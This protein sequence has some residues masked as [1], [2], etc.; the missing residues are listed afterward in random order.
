MS[1]ISRDKLFFRRNAL[2]KEY[3][4]HPGLLFLNLYRS[5]NNSFYIVQK[6]YQDFISALKKYESDISL[7][8]MGNEVNRHLAIMETL[9]TL[10]NYL[11]SVLSLI[12]HSRTFIKNECP[13]LTESI[14]SQIDTLSQKGCVKFTREFRNFIQHKN[15]PSPSMKITYIRE[16]NS[17]EQKI[18]FNKKD[19]LEWD[20]WSKKSRKYI[21]SFGEELT[22]NKLFEDYQKLNTK[23]YKLIC[24]KAVYSHKEEIIA[25]FK[26]NQEIV[27]IE[28]MLRK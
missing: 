18:Y 17:L 6:N 20:K 5:L 19:L 12:D 4:S 2:I 7:M 27:K 13:E 24:K 10:H 14:S 8:A 21:E 15:L 3:E 9:R 1:Q 25:V 23:N 22:L 11:A 28:Q 26:I 16:P